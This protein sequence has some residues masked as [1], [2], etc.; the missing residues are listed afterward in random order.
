MYS[1]LVWA[2]IKNSAHILAVLADVLRERHFFNTP[3]LLRLQLECLITAEWILAAPEDARNERFARMMKRALAEQDRTQ[4]WSDQM[5]AISS[6]HATRMV[7]MAYL[8]EPEVREFKG[9]RPAPSIRQMAEE[10]GSI[11]LYA[12][13]RY[14]SHL[15][16]AGLGIHVRELHFG[17][18]Y[19]RV[20][21]LLY[22]TEYLWKILNAGQSTIIPA[23]RD[24]FTA[25]ITFFRVQYLEKLRDAFFSAVVARSCSKETDDNRLRDDHHRDFEQI[26]A[27]WNP[28]NYHAV[29]EAVRKHLR[30]T[31]E[32]AVRGVWGRKFGVV[33]MRVRN[34]SP[35]SLDVRVGVKDLSF[36][37]L[38]RFI[39]P[40][41]R[42]SFEWRKGKRTLYPNESICL[43]FP[44]NRSDEEKLRLHVDEPY[45]GPLHV[46]RRRWGGLPVSGGDKGADILVV[47]IS[48][49]G[50]AEAEWRTVQQVVVA[51]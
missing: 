13:Y 36:S 14:W 40:P 51:W 48:T 22:G 32:D 12:A 25:F 42:H 9:A 39:E 28:L 16:H 44:A 50:P 21:S 43:M 5:G 46:Y 33:S 7:A 24:E 17:L 4:R 15:S 2:Y 37:R 47:R 3:N 27:P 34:N 45:S 29:D 10:A 11:D 41:W 35:E 31:A 19:E 30:V 49:L 20:Q 1:V 8:D 38:S 18:E 23:F 6:D 26:T